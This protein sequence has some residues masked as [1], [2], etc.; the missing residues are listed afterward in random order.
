MIVSFW[1]LDGMPEDS[2]TPTAW[3]S[4]LPGTKCY[5]RCVCAT[6]VAARRFLDR[7]RHAG[8]LDAERREAELVADFDKLAACPP[9]A[10]PPALDVDT[11]GAVDVHALA[12]QI[13]RQL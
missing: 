13:L 8:H 10:L 9:L 2:G 6:D 7:P 5:L 4:S 3:L 11:R 12:R 1:H